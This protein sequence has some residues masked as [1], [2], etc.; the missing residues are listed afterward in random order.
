MVVGQVLNAQHGTVSLASDGNIRFTPD[1]YY[2]GI[3]AVQL[4][5]QHARGRGRTSQRVRDCH[6]GQ[7]RSASARR[8][9]LAAAREPGA[10]DP[11]VNAPR[12][13]HRRRQRRANDHQRHRVGRPAGRDR[14][15]RHDPGD[16]QHLLLR[17]NLFRLHRSRPLGR[18]VDRPGRRRRRQAQHGTGRRRRQDRGL[19]RRADPREQ[20]DRDRRQ[21]AACQRQR[22]RG[23]HAHD[24]VGREHRWR[25][26]APARQRH[27]PVHA[28]RQFQRRRSFHLH[29]R[30][31]QR[32]LRQRR[33]Q[34]SPMQPST[35]PLS[36]RTTRSTATTSR[37]SAASTAGR[38]PHSPFRS[39]I[40]SRTTSTWSA[41]RSPSKRRGTPTTGS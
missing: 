16:T 26:C 35:S 21:R 11:P 30:R 41:T 37:S 33:P 24:R 19:P 14:R 13:R 10:H 23:R 5:R 1:L 38:T 4:H 39:S 18:D 22:P 29:H 31:R 8:R 40:C 17:R 20:P 2:R 7:P 25:R 28:R 36:R 27:N 32:R 12:Q 34:L 15:R 9:P 3:G 6:A